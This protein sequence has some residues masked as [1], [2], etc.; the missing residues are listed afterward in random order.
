M[1]LDANLKCRL[2]ESIQRH[3]FNQPVDPKA[4]C[5]ADYLA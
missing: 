2:P 5:I 3:A 1:E 4:L